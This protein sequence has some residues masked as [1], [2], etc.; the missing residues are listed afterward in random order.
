[1]SDIAQIATILAMWKQPC[2]PAAGIPS[3]IAD[4]FPALNSGPINEASSDVKLRELL[5][6]AIQSPQVS[7]LLF[8]MVARSNEALAQKKSAD[9]QRRR[10]GEG[11]AKQEPLGSSGTPPM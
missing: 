2:F 4:S 5:R 11:P 10:L 7:S 1:M 8:S 6:T 9:A 3:P